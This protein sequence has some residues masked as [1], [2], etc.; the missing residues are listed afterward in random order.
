MGRDFAQYVTEPDK[1]TEAYR[2]VLTQGSLTDVQLTVRHRDGTET[3]VLC[4]LSVYRG[5]A[6]NVLGVLATGRD[7]TRQNQAFEL[8]Q[9]MEAIVEGSDDAIIGRTLEGIITSWNPAAE[10]MYGY[11]GEEVIG[12]SVGMLIPEDRTD[13]M[14]TILGGIRAGQRVE[15]L[16][17]IR[18]R[19]DGTVFPISLTV[20]PI[21]GAGGA[22]VG[23][24][25]ICRDLTEQEHAAQYARS[26]IEA[27][28]DPMVTISPEGQI[29]DVNE[30]T[31]RLTGVPRDELIGTGFSGYFTDP[32]KANE[33]HQRAFA[34]GSVTDYPLTLRHR[35]GTLTDLLLNASVY[36][37]TGGRVLGVL[38]AARDMTTQKEA[39]EAAQRMAA[40]VEFS[41]E[42]IVGG[43]PEGV[44]TSWNPA[45]ERLFGYSG[46]EVLGKSIE[47]L[48][49]G[50]G[51][52]E[53]LA[54]LAR[55]REGEVV[56]NFGTGYVRK[57]RTVVPVSITFAPIRDADGSV[58][59]VSSIVRDVTAQ[60]EAE[61]F[62]R[63][64]AAI[65]FSGEAII[66]ET[67]DGV[68]TSWNPAA[69]RL[70]G[71]SGHEIVGRSIELLSPGDRTGEITA[72]LAR[73]KAGQ[74]VEHHET[75]RARKDGTAIRV[76]VTV[77]PIRGANGAIVGAAVIHRELTE[78]K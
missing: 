78:Q 75:I 27:G 6:G 34:Q 62:A 66:S 64:A 47:V 65:E 33:I 10:R 59:G 49:P 63:L 8:A 18:V 48:S 56:E 15:S 3:D 19:K 72:M 13:E 20:S 1:A 38:A 12:Q 35:V 24:S 76:S 26:L 54:I 7:V 4:N 69:E 57:D 17:T 46:Q 40:I 11:R 32:G 61:R 16:E 60:R 71:Y 39:F 67:L 2:Q 22:I 43:T 30:A 28:L 9:R 37:D 51:T 53:I 41:G 68:V 23:A 29:D 36:R 77:S 50:V 58:V 21:R 14:R 31:V 70:F 45:A 25:V 73:V 74:L 55:V 44:V 52:G 42:A 5:T